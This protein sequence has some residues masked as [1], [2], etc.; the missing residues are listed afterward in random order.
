MKTVSGHYVGE[1]YGGGIVVSVWKESGVEHGLIASLTDLSTSAA[2]SNVTTLVGIIAHSPV[3]GQAN[4][5]AIIAQSGHTQS[6]AKLCDDYTSGSFSDWYLPAEWELDQCYN[7]ALVV[8]TILGAANGF[9]FGR[10][11]SST[12]FGDN[13]V[14]Y[15]VFK[16]GGSS[17]DYSK[18]KTYRVRAVRRF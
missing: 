6:A 14:W 10:Y 3:D 8:N 15:K 11:W 13:A 7:A 16:Y 17:E 2:W 18:T 1:L 12:E 9:G 4:T 5:N